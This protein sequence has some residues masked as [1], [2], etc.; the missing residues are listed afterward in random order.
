[1]SAPWSIGWGS[2]AMTD[3]PSA[4]TVEAALRAMGTTDPVAWSAV[5][6]AAC[7]KHGIN[8]QARVAAFLA[9]VVH[10]SGGMRALVEN[11]NY[12]AERLPAVFGAHRISAD[13]AA[14]L[15]RTAGHP[16]NQQA[17]ANCVYGGAW[18]AKNLGNTEN[19]DGWR[20]RGRGLIQLTGRGNYTRFAAKIG[21]PLDDLPAL[22]ETREGAADSAAAFWVVAG[23]NARVDVGDMTGARRLVN[24]GTLGLDDVLKYA[25]LAS[26]ALGVATA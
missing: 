11:L 18:G 23:C 17:I 14:H 2:N 21:V 19:G 1:M 3:F 9:N 22:L 12:A 5:L 20:F 15:G 24:G 8:T 10:E 4:K 26:P 6:A 13:V 25:A 7:Q 16:A